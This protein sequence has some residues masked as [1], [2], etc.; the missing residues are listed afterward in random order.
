M[1]LP[2]E[3]NDIVVGDGADS[4]AGQ[5]LAVEDA[6]A[7]SLTRFSPWHL[8]LYAPDAPNE[9]EEFRLD[10][11][12]WLRQLA[13]GTYERAALVRQEARVLPVRLIVT[14]PPQEQ[15]E[16][17]R[18]HK[19]KQAR[20][21]GRHLSQEALFVAG[22]HL[23]V[24]TLPRSRWPLPLVLQ[25]YQ[26]RW[27][28]EIFFK[29]LKGVLDLHRLRWHTAESVLAVLA[30]LL[31]GWLLL[32]D[33][34]EQ[35]RREIADAEPWAFPISSWQLDQWA[36]WS[37]RQVIEGWCSPQRLR[38]LAPELRPLFRQKRKRPLREEQRRLQ[39]QAL[40]TPQPDL[41]IHFGCSSASVDA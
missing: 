9:S 5:L 21:K 13:P 26:A 24:T 32:E 27:Q 34:A 31:V 25:L 33:Q 16:A 11:V 6:Q 38:A 17:L 7:F 37:L 20:A 14:V 3:P 23:L 39:F 15:A 40:L 10:I 35:L 36:F 18:R 28:I 12:G 8:V 29:R 30:A 1:H 22:F 41:V 2:I 19:E 4:R